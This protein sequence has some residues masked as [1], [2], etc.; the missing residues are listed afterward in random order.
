MCIRDRSN[1]CRNIYYVGS[2]ENAAKLSGIN[3]DRVK[4]FVYVVIA[5]LSACLSLIHIW[6]VA[7]LSE[8]EVPRKPFS[9]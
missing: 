8:S 3:V 1:A 5:L 2:N 7:E 4:I 6:A 9:S